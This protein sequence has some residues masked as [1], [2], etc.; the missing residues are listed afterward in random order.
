MYLHEKGKELYD[1]NPEH[2]EVAVYKRCMY[3]LRNDL[4]LI[5]LGDKANSG[6]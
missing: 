3:E 2:K 1:T 5:S 4:V 6:S